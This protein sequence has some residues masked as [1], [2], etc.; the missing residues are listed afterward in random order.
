LY[1]KYSNQQVNMTSNG[2]AQQAPQPHGSH[3]DQSSPNSEAA[4]TTAADAN[5]LSNL[6]HDVE[7]V[8][9]DI[10]S[11]I[12]SAKRKLSQL[13]GGS[14]AN[15]S[16]HVSGDVPAPRLVGIET[17]PGPPKKAKAKQTVVTTTV[18]RGGNQGQRQPQAKAK[19]KQR[20]KVGSSYR[21]GDYAA[22]LRVL[23]KP[24]SSTPVR[25]GGSALATAIVTQRTRTIV[26]TS[27]TISGYCFI[28]CPYA[29]VPLYYATLTS[30]T[31]GSY[32]TVTGGNVPTASVIQQSFGSMRPIAGG[33]RV[34]LVAN[35]TV[36]QGINYACLIPTG[37]VSTAF[38]TTNV[39]NSPGA[40]IGDARK[41]IECRW[42]P[43][44]NSE[45]AFAQTYVVNTPS[46]T[47]SSVPYLFV[48]L[49]NLSTSTSV[50]VEVE[51]IWHWEATVEIGSQGMIDATIGNMTASQ[52]EQVTTGATA[53]ELLGN[54]VDFVT[55]W[56]P[57]VVGGIQHVRRAINAAAAA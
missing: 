28:A 40:V 9:A 37:V 57:A 36:N 15:A 31:W 20:P 7:R 51:L 5:G 13:N 11:T 21:G 46:L 26:S 25:L 14:H 27:S 39:A 50:G 8:F 35:D 53:T 34:R 47:N 43:Q 16:T 18:K 49:D 3:S 19:T 44:D 30:G 48:G 54:A 55:D 24:F 1:E 12:Q 32:A 2:T 38:Y 6:G 56:G 17:N 41:T 33:L 10:E 23:Q 4:T 42:R 52:Q 45:F 29:T 22:Y